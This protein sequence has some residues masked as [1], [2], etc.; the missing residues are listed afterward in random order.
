MVYTFDQFSYTS[1]DIITS[2]KY[3]AISQKED[4]RHQI[5]YIKTDVFYYNSQIEWRGKLH[6][7]INELKKNNVIVGH[8]D[9]EVNNYIVDS[10][11]FKKWFCINH[12]CTRN[13]VYS[14]PLGITNNT[15]ESTDHII[16]GNTDIMM[17]VNAM[18]V[19]RQHLVYLNVS[20]TTHPERRYVLE[21]FNDKDYV[22][23]R[24]LVKTLED[25]RQF[26]IDIKSSKFVLC[27]RGN[28]IDTH[29]LWETLYMGSIPIVR[30]EL[31][32]EQHTDLPILIVDNWND[33][34]EEFLEAKYDEIMSKEWNLDKLKIGYWEDFIRNSI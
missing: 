15:N 22:Y 7:S 21:V 19:E 18:K 4:L 3:L 8:S 26:L 6:P 34:T 31:M 12:N 25:R 9:Y 32:Y 17:E 13:N 1:D 20:P 16:F 24:K 14:L 10:H 29:R 27:P 28:G 23:K 30:R 2:D 11:S 33:V 5:T